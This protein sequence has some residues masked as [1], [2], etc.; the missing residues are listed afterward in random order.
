[1]FQIETQFILY[2]SYCKIIY[3]YKL[4]YYLCYLYVNNKNIQTNITNTVKRKKKIDHIECTYI[5][6]DHIELITF[7]RII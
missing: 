7:C 4:H 6:F 5:L 1:M 3:S 2:D